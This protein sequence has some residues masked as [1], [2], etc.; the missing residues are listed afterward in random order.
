MIYT[1]IKRVFHPIGQGAFYSERHDDYNI[2][3]DCGEWKNSKE[4]TRLVENSFSSNSVIH[5]LFIS[6]FDFDHVSKIDVLKNNFTIQICIL[7]LLTDDQKQIMTSFYK[8]LAKATITNFDNLITLINNPEQYFGTQTKIIY[9]KDVSKENK[10]NE[11]DSRSPI[12]YDSLKSDF[13]FKNATEIESGTQISFNH[14]WIYMPYNINY[15]Q[16]KKELEDIFATPDPA[17]GECLDI[18]EFIKNIDYALK[19]CSKIKKI[20]DKLQGKINLNSMLLYSGPSLNKQ[21][22]LLLSDRLYGKCSHFPTY[23]SNEYNIWNKPA[24]I[25]T[26]DTNLNSVDIKEI[27]HDYWH[28]VGTIQL[29]HHGAESAFAFSLLNDDENFIFP[30][31]YGRKNT[32]GHPSD[33]VII[34]IASQ[35]SCVVHINEGKETLY[36]QAIRTIGSI[37]S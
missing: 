34:E 16:R 21:S 27:F 31:S 37:Y 36:I 25:F 29:P 19:N 13:K 28:Y 24:C 17:T 11:E 1:T 33:N 35:G 12:S 18:L 6:H 30:V 23:W 5:M 2:V 10:N 20:Y 22:T 32:Y 14:N 26:G 4:S 3:Y 9:V 15:S 7:P 8:S